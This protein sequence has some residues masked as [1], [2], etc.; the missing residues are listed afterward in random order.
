MFS[1]N[2]NVTRQPP[3]PKRKAPAARRYPHERSKGRKRRARQDHRSSEFAHGFHP[4]RFYLIS[5]GPTYEQR[6]NE[7]DGHFRFAVASDECLRI[8]F[9]CENVTVRNVIGLVQHAAGAR[10]TKV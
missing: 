10:S 9:D 4:K 8:P 1:L 3:E 7:A 2:C 6:Q 5:L